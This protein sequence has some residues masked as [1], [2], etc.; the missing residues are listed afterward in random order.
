MIDAEILRS[1]ELDLIGT[2]AFGVMRLAVSLSPESGLLGSVP[3]AIAEVDRELAAE[4]VDR[5]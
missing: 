5:A 4:A 1:E 2:S 3:T